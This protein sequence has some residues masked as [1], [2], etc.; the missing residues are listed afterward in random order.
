MMIKKRISLLGNQE[1]Q[2]NEIL[3]NKAALEDEM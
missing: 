3:G 2:E 1:G